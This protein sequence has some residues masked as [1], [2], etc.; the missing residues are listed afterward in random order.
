MSRLSVWPKGTFVLV[1]VGLLA[2]I[3]SAQAQL[4][5]SF[6]NS[7][8]GWSISP[9]GSAN[10]QANFQ[11]SGFSPTGATDGTTSLAVGAT[12][13]NAG[14]GPDYSQLLI[15]PNDRTTAYAM[16]VTNI[17]QNA[18]SISFDV[19]TPPASFGFF[20]Q[21]QL[22]INNNGTGFT[23]LNGYDAVTIGSE[24]TLTVPIS[25]A[26]RA[27][28]AGSADGTTMIFQVGGGYTAGNET[29]Y[30]DNIRATPAPAPEPMSLGVLAIGSLAMLRRWR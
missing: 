23:N 20:L 13:A 25:A 9:F 11:L 22:I 15:S 24:T 30:L 14:S 19:F 4:I 6:E 17:L 12:A 5:E 3:Q 29:F 7:A 18:Q 1:F 26:Q 16:N 8:D 21:W 2:S 27:Q 28:L 10:Q